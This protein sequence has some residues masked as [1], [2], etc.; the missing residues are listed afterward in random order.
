MDNPFTLAHF[1]P[2]EAEKITG[3]S[4]AMQRDWRHRGFLPKNEGHARFDLF[5]LATM[6]ALKLFAD[7]G[8]GPQVAQN[9][10]EISSRAIAWFALEFEDAYEGKLSDSLDATRRGL[11]NALGLPRIVPSRFLVV[12]ADGSE[13]WDNSI[14]N[15]FQKNADTD[16]FAG[17]V[18]VLD[19][20]IL[21]DVLIERADRALVHINSS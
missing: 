3:L 12:F 14:E 15:A 10:T 19:L 20:M 13:W 11:W 7:R 1:A 2:S 5:T 8:I 21:G 9:F 18:I 4:T 17:P 6:M 16:K